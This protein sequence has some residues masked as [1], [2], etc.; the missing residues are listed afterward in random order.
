M[1]EISQEDYEKLIEDSL[2]FNALLEAGVDD[3]YGYDRAK[4]IY[5]EWVNE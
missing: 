4:E 3:W 2:M 5:N 1:I